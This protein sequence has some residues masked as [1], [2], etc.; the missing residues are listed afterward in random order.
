[1]VEMTSSTP[2][3][4]RR[5]RILRVFDMRHGDFLQKMGKS[6]ELKDGLD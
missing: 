2:L 5:A 3:R 6:H 1:M 4:R